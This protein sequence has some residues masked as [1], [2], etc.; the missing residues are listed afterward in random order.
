[1]LLVGGLAAISIIALAG[2]YFGVLKRPAKPVS[3]TAAV[4]EKSIAVLPFENLS[5]EK[6]NSYFAAGVQDEVLANLARIADL[7][8]INRT[9]R[10][11]V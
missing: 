8:V 7:K 6:E 9:I 5:S 1:M 4:P 10:D 3:Q 11:P 2:L